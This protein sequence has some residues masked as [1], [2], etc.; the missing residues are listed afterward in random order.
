MLAFSNRA[1]ACQG[2][3]KS[4]M[5]WIGWSRPSPG[6]VK[7]NVDG[8][9]LKGSRIAGQEELSDMQQEDR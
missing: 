8:R 3:L 5:N 2:E 4:K 6:W 1:I 9:T 7:L